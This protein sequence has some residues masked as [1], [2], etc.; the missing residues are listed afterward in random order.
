MNPPTLLASSGWWRSALP[1]TFHA[2]SIMPYIPSVLPYTF[3]AYTFH[4]SSIMPYQT[5]LMDDARRPNV[6]SISREVRG[7][8]SPPKR[9][10]N[11]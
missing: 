6:Y 7:I 8:V 10:A 3:H 4:A 2:S 9:T 11:F 5:I 1:Y